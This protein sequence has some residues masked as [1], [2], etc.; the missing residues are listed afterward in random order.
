MKIRAFNVRVGISAIAFT[1]MS[2]PGIAA[3][4]PRTLSVDWSSSDIKNYVSEA[5]RGTRASVMPDDESRLSKLKLPVIGFERVPSLLNN[6][7]APGARSAAAAPARTLV[8]DEE[9]PV[10]YQIT[11]RYDGITVSVDADLRLQEELPPSAKVFGRIPAP[12]ENVKVQVIDGDSEPG[13]EGA[14]AEYT[15][16]KYPNIPY[17]VTIECEKRTREYCR[18]PASIT[19]DSQFLKLISA[20]PPQD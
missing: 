13:L 6:S 14:I 11:E 16:Y 8:M 10:W 20:R 1:A 19:K 7:L 15:V 18:N 4:A 17:R 9:Q 12:D 2:L 3:E 5:Q